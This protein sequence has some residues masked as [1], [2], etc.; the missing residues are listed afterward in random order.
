MTSALVAK[1][2]LTHGVN[3]RSLANFTFAMIVTFCGDSGAQAFL[4]ASKAVVGDC[5]VQLWPFVFALW[6]FT[7]RDNRFVC[8]VQ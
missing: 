6:R 7:Y 4:Q 8:H 5:V 2:L 3:S 1:C